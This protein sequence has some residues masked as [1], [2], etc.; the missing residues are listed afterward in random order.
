MAYR[1]DLKIEQGATLVLD[2]A[3]QDDLGRPMDL[4]GYSAAAQI[5][6]RHSDP[7]PAA[8][9]SSTL[10]EEPGVVSFSL[11]AQ[12]TSAL[13]RTYG[14]WDCELTAPDLTV[15]RLAE[16]KVSVTPEVTR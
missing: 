16:G 10:G 14:V 4:T 1:Y 6:Y 9:F 3:C 13:S 15:Q 11:S 5:R 7:D 8:V 2:V 12:Q